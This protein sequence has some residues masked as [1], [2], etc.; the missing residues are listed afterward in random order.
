[1]PESTGKVSRWHLPPAVFSKGRET[2][3]GVVVGIRGDHGHPLV[4]S[5]GWWS[6]RTSIE[7]GAEAKGKPWEGTSL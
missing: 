2:S 4:P 7:T 3:L 6:R 5:W 1:M